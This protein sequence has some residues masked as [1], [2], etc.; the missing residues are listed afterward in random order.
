MKINNNHCYLKFLKSQVYTYMKRF[1][2]KNTIW[3]NLDLVYALFG[4][5][6]SLFLTLTQLNSSYILIYLATTLA[7]DDFRLPTP[8]S[9]LF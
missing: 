5:T 9:F 2:I 1:P 6:I 8:N 3:F 4:K 7:Y